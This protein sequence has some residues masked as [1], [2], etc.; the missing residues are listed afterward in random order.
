M[1]L[2]PFEL[3]DAHWEKILLYINLKAKEQGL[4]E[5]TAVFFLFKVFWLQLDDQAV[6]DAFIDD[7]VLASLEAR[8]DILDGERPG[9]DTEIEAIKTRLGR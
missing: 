9:L 7:Q 2:G 1:P 3:D 6:L 4:T 5:P 8:R